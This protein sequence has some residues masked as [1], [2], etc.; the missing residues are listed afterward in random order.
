M[1]N[2]MARVDAT[3]HVLEY[4]ANLSISNRG[5]ARLVHLARRGFSLVL[6]NTHLFR[7]WKGIPFPL[8]D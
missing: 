5:F 3:L 4:R 8:V 1:A 7:G 6:D 2:P